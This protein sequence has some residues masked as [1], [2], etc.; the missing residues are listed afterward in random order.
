MVEGVIG[1]IVAWVV[2]VISS[3]GY[4]GIF[5][6]MAIESASIPLPSEIIMPFSG[7]LVSQGKFNFYLVIT[8]G[9][10]G[11][12]FGSILMYAL[13]YWGQETFVKRFV[14][15]WG[16]ILISE[17]ELI[18]GE[19]WFRRYGDFIVFTSRVL[20]VARTFISLPAGIAKVDFKKFCAFTLAGS[21]AWS[22]FLTFIGVKLG[23]NWSILEP[24][25]RKFDIAFMLL[26][27]IV[28]GGYLFFRF[29]RLS[30]S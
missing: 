27:I 1:L 26:A 5:I 12:L 9:G 10:A 22:A 25:F 3:L 4:L 11:N 21:M 17:H 20:P 23:D 13:G 29:R 24:I 16:R 28:A 18:R 2:D 14:R 7:F 19:K 8:A 6:T 30:G 15:G